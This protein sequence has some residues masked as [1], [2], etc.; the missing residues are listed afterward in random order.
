MVVPSSTNLNLLQLTDGAVVGHTTDLPSVNQP[1][2]I[3]GVPNNNKN[4]IVT[5]TKNNNNKMSHSAADSTV[6]FSSPDLLPN[7]ALDAE[8]ITP[9]SSL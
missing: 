2:C 9:A 1:P 4:T 7:L 3:I 5:V 8:D 6:F